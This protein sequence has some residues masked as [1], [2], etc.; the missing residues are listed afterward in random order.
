VCGGGARSDVWCQLI[1]DVT[2]VRTFRSTDSEVGAKGA[3]ITGLVATGREPDHEHAAERL[4]RARDE[5]DPR[6]ELAGAY[7]ERFEAFTELRRTVAPGWARMAR[8]G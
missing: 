8:I 2:G 6:E 4:V 1:A 3:L 7:A 5:F